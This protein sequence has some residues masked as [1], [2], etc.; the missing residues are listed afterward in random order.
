MSDSGYR[1]RLGSVPFPHEVLRG[2]STQFAYPPNEFWDPS[3]GPLHSVADPALAW[4]HRY[5]ER[6]R[7]ARGLLNRFVRCSLITR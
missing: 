6:R 3:L 7:V 4:P 5:L 2:K 1:G